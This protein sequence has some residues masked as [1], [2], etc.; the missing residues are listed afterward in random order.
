MGDRKNIFDQQVRNDQRAYDK[1]KIFL[2]GQGDYTTDF[3][4]DHIYFKNY[5]KKYKRNTTNWVYCKSR[6]TMANINVFHY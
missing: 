2:I 6:S 1:V 5:H 4:L 3:I